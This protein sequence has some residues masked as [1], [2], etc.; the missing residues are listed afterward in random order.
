MTT[1]PRHQVGGAAQCVNWGE[2]YLITRMEKR[3]AGT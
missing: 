1:A 2:D 3:I